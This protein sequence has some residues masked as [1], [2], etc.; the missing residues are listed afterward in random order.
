MTTKK[1]CLI[2]YAALLMLF[3]SIIGMASAVT[4]TVGSETGNTTISAA[5]ANATDGATILVTDGNYTEDDLI[6][7]MEVTIISENG[8]QYTSI[9]SNSSSDTLINITAN[10]V[11]ING[12]SIIGDDYLENDGIYLNS[13][14]NTNIS[15]NEIYEFDEGLYTFESN[16]TLIENNIFSSNFQSIF[17]DC[18]TNNTM[19]NNTMHSSLGFGVDGFELEHF[20]HT[21]DNNT[22]NNTISNTIN[23][24]KLYYW[25]NASDAEI[26]S[27]AGQVYVIN[28]TNITVKDLELI[29]T[30]DGVA[31]IDTDNSR[32]E[33]V[34]V[35]LSSY[36]LTLIGSNN[37]TLNDN[38]VGLC[39]YDGIYFVE[40]HN[41]TLTDN[42]ATYTCL[43]SEQEQCSGIFLGGSNN[44][45]LINNIA[46]GN[47]ES[48]I[49]LWNS[50]N[51]TLRGNDASENYLSGLYLLGSTNNTLADNLVNGASD[52]FFF[53]M[54]TGMNT[55]SFEDDTDNENS[56]SDLFS[57]TVSMDIELFE[58]ALQTKHVV[59]KR[60]PVVDGININ[61]ASINAINIGLLH[62]SG[63]FLDSSPNNVL[64]GNQV[65]FNEYDFATVNSEN[66]E[67]NKLML[68]EDQAEMSFTT[69]GFYLYLK[70]TDSNS[71]SLQGKTN[72]NGYI[73][74]FYSTGS[75]NISDQPLDAEINIVTTN[76]DLK[77]L[78]DDSGMSR[79]GESSIGLYKLNGTEWIKIPNATLNA[80]DNYVFGTLSYTEDGF[81][82]NGIASYEATLALFKDPEPSTSRSGSSVIAREISQGRSTDLPVGGDGEITGDTVV[83]S[84]NAATTLTLYKGTKAVDAS[85]NPVNR[86][87][88]TTPSSLPS[89]TPAE[90][91]ESGLYFRFGPSGTTFSQD[92]MITMEFDPEDFEGRAP[93][94]YTYTSEDGWIALE[95]T[96]DWENGRATAMISHFSLYA[97]F[98]TDGEPEKEILLEPASESTEFTP[99]EEETSVKESEDENGFG[100]LPWII[101]I[102]IIL[103]LGIVYVN[104]QKG[105]EGL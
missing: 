41:N 3:V 25:I 59:S 95:T 8:S 76:M 21:I 105:N 20:I 96:V 100:F 61:S 92:V 44:N 71:V 43:S 97:L 27:D 12:F 33:N 64:T 90:V 54:D 32:I 86:I 99:V 19:V 78:Y 70:G 18:S 31:F 77:F 67:V 10:N 79:A 87:I 88:V 13:V 58:N 93:V 91:V 73:D 63:I 101:G 102:A 37:N 85:G 4:I 1:S 94:I 5:L 103:G 6:I 2:K 34:T 14:S 49:L 104:K 55:A 75:F 53:S 51:N 82:I 45:S 38:A 65:L 56:F 80:V 89:D 17:F 48:G 39:L 72:V 83:K 36:G 29:G 60:N 42:I 68:I 9:I 66:V 74:L 69:D 57:E 84:S 28:S 81:S 47:V 35:I 7:D 24:K 30:Y 26:P 46:I 15:N 52:S 50:D 40:S 11:T 22:I 23:T 98:G 62:G 16:N